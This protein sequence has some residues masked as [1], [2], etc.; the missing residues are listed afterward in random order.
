MA[1]GEEA[2][3]HLPCQAATPQPQASGGFP[4]RPR[5]P[6]GL[7]HA[8][9]GAGWKGSPKVTA[10]REAQTLLCWAGLRGLP[11]VLNRQTFI[12]IFR[13]RPVRATHGPW[14]PGPGRARVGGEGRRRRGPPARQA[15]GQGGKVPGEASVR[16]E[17]PSARVAD[18]GPS[19][20]SPD[21][22]RVPG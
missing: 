15:E 8:R 16:G 17:L 10:W 13:T 3:G 18:V 19:C 2:G 4:G 20:P 1:T 7:P 11:R 14:E 9:A 21:R 6:A 5:Q 22:S 12:P